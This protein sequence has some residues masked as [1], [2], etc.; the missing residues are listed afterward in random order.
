HGLEDMHEDISKNSLRENQECPPS[1][2]VPTE[3][4][5]DEKLKRVRSVFERLSGGGS[6]KEPRDSV[7]YEQIA[8]VPLW[9]IILGLC[10]SVARSPEHKMSSLAYA[11]PSIL[12]H[13]DEMKVFPEGDMTA[14]A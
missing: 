6:W 3:Q 5:D 2:S 7:S 11:V 13:F 14:L 10:Y 12:K 8:H 4:N 9:H 1:S